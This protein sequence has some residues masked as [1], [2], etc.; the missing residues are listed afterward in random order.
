M[1][2]SDTAD[3]AVDPTPPA[4]PAEGAPPA[5]SE[6]EET[7]TSEDSEE[8][9]SETPSEEADEPAPGGVRDDYRSGRRFEDFPLSPEVLQ[10]LKELGYSEATEVQ[11]EAI[12]PGLAGRDLLVRAKTGTGKTCA[13]GVP[14][15][16]ALEPGARAVQGLVLSPTRELA[17]QIAKEIT[18]IAKYKD[19]RILTV[20]GGVGMGPQEAA[21]EEGVELVVGTPGRVLDHIRRGNLDLSGAKTVCLDEADEMLSMGFFKDV[22]KIVSQAPR[23]S[24]LLLFSATVSGDVKR[25]V[26][27]YLHDPVDIYLSSDTDRVEGIRHL[28]YETG[29]DM[30]RVKALLSVVDKENPTSAIVFCNTRE[31]TSTVA[32]YLDRQ[33]I[34]CQLL[35]GELPQKK[36]EQVMAKMKGG[37]VHFLISTD[38]AAR[39]IDISQLS[40]VINYNLPQDPAVYLHRVGRTGRIGHEGTAISL[41]GGQDL[42]TRLVLEKQFQIDFEVQDLPTAEEA[43]E[44]RLQRHMARLKEVMA[45][46]AFEG[47]LPTVRALKDRPGGELLLATA[48]RVFFDWD[49]AQRAAGGVDSI[50]AVQQAK[51]EKREGDRGRGGGRGRR[52]GGRDSGRDRGGRDGGGRDGRRRSSRRDSSAKKDSAKPEASGDGGAPRKRRRRRRRRKSE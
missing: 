42:S 18:A 24:Q 15:V 26:D 34:E 39:G 5:D 14:L 29:P 30:H 46:T 16:E 41:A 44:L 28:L 35:S 9:P 27:K 38:V 25:L 17:N 23:E 48:M 6:T 33:G 1:S 45:T 52:G 13:F 7:S 40:H 32:T 19:V 2:T 11:A 47:Y 10:G 51:A 8:S 49:R 4:E 22:T 31:D 50:G 21:L 20:Y 3:S 36:R 43:A 37:Q 12:E